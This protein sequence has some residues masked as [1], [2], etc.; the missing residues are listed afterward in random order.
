MA[1]NYLEYAMEEQRKER[2]G[3]CT[4]RKGGTELENGRYK[5]RRGKRD[6]AEWTHSGVRCQ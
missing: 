1:E 3:L 6:F 4:G 2:E 5:L